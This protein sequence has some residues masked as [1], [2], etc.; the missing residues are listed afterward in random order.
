T[1]QAH[2]RGAAIHTLSQLFLR[3]ADPAVSAA[4]VHVQLYTY[5]DIY[6]REIAGRF[7]ALRGLAPIRAL[8]EAF[9]R[10]FVLPQGY[11]QSAESGPSVPSGPDTLTEM[12]NAHR[13]AKQAMLLPLHERKRA[14][15]R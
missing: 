8:A 13:I 10:R 1:A 6:A 15:G 14:W 4:C 11:L 9:G 7:G 3:I 5:N 12:A 2:P